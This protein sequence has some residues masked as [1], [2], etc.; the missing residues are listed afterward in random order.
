MY[1]SCGEIGICRNSI[2]QTARLM[3]ME[4]NIG[5][6][7]AVVRPSSSIETTNEYFFFFFGG[8]GEG[9]MHDEKYI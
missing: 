9:L 5:E 6:I 1:I 3:K 7:E 4:E 8:D 2:L